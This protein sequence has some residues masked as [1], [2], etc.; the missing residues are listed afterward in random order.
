MLQRLYLALA[1]LLF[2]VLLS[3]CAL[4]HNSERG[5]APVACL[6]F[7]PNGT[8]L[9]LC[10]GLEDYGKSYGEVMLWDVREGSS[11]AASE[12]FRV[13]FG[14][15]P[16]RRTGHCSPQRRASLSHSPS[17]RPC[18]SHTG[19]ARP[20]PLRLRLHP[21]HLPA[22]ATAGRGC[23]PHYRAAHRLQPPAHPR[24]PGG[25]DASQLPPCL[26]AIRISRDYNSQ[27]KSSLARRASEETVEPAAQARFDGFL[28][29]ASG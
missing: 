22:P 4:Q 24:P 2:A 23:R 6:K 26:T 13:W 7:S 17:G 16:I 25:G 27:K 19:P 21:A 18:A 29:C 8:T 1:L 20:R 5:L 10:C 12:A 3:S 15:W 28:A 14:T 11:S 9:A